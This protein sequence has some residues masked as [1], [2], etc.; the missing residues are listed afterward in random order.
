MALI[1]GRTYRDRWGQGGVYLGD[2]GRGT[3]LGGQHW[4]SFGFGNNG[5][6]G[7]YIEEEMT[8]IP[9]DTRGYG[10]TP[11]GPLNVQTYTG[12]SLSAEQQANARQLAGQGAPL[13][14]EMGGTGAV[15]TNPIAA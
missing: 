13:P 10:Y 8:E 9:A 14:V 1:V 2:A 15:P 5:S 4:G 6:S 12:P 3:T 11:A 7:Q